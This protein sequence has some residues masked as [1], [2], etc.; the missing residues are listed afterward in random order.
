M[1]LLRKKVIPITKDL[2]DEYKSPTNMLCHARFDKNSKGLMIFIGNTL[3]GYIIWNIA[4]KEIKALET[5]KEFRGMG[6]ASFMLEEA[7]EEGI[8]KLTVN[9]RNTNALQLYE[10]LGYE[11]YNETPYMYFM[12]K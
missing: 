6:I 8:V 5:I 9:K 12:K 7:E 10:S 2:I 4:D 3:A 1:K 11:I